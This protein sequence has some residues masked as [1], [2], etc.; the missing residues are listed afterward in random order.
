MNNEFNTFYNSAEC[1]GLILTTML[2]S[3][4]GYWEQHGKSPGG[5]LLLSGTRTEDC[6]PLAAMFGT[7]NNV[8][9]FKLRGW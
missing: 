3:T 7:P 2:T 1:R 9:T 5:D 6:W 8:T 4:D